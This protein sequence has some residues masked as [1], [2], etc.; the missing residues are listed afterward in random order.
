MPTTHYN[1]GHEFSTR[2]KICVMQLSLL[3]LLKN[4]RITMLQSLQTD[5]SL[6]ANNW[7][8]CFQEPTSNLK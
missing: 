2:D 8:Y 7:V 1:S 5:E 4:T 3:V 6:W